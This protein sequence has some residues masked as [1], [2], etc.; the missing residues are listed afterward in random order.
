MGFA[1]PAP[2]LTAACHCEMRGERERLGGQHFSREMRE[3]VCRKTYLWDQSP[4]PG[5][6][7]DSGK[8]K[9]SLSN[10]NCNCQLVAGLLL[11]KP[12]LEHRINKG[13]G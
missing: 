13:G 9:S 11:L 6:Q 2:M 4:C 5:L 8:H 12:H 10:D 3:V 1:V 7:A